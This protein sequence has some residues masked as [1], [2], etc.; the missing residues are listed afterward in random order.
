MLTYL[1]LL[2]HLLNHIF[3]LP[4]DPSANQSH[5]RHKIG[6]HLPG[7]PN[8]ATKHRAAKQRIRRDRPPA[9]AADNQPD[10]VLYGLAAALLD[11]PEWPRRR[12]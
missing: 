8:V 5:R 9:A 3:F 12:E 2:K 11:D 10:A 4:S 1:Y 6:L 7:K